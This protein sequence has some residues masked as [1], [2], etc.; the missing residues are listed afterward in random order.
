MIQELY[1]YE[2]H[3]QKQPGT[4]ADSINICVHLPAGSAVVKS[5]PQGNW[6]TDEWCLK[7]DLRTDIKIQLEFST[8]DGAIPNLGTVSP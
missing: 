5:S 6:K 3:V 7:G 4:V 2:L 8:S 1:L